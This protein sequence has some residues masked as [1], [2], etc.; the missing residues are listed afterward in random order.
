MI[1]YKSLQGD[2]L[3]VFGLDGFDKVRNDNDLKIS[4][5]KF[6]QICVKQA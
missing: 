2:K 4:E 1:H 5:R 6:R 3:C